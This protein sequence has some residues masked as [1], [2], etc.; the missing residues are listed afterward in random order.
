MLQQSW[1]SVQESSGDRQVNMW[2]MGN[3]QTIPK[4]VTRHTT[5]NSYNKGRN[6]EPTRMTKCTFLEFSAKGT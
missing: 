3:D 1:G 2:G 5:N 6:R 4:R